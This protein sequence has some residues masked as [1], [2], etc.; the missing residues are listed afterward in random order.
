[1]ENRIIFLV[2]EKLKSAPWFSSLGQ[3][4]NDERV[5]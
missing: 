5:V 4:V 1:M 2:I 3:P